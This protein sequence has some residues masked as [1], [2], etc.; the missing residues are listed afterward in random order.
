VSLLTSARRSLYPFVG[1][2]IVHVRFGVFVLIWAGVVVCEAG[3]FIFW[4]VVVVG[5]S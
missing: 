4:P 3:I 5:Q 1:A 2:G